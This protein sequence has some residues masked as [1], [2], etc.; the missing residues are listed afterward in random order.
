MT[1]N[2]YQELAMR[3]SSFES[4]LTAAVLG[5]C[6]ESGE[7]ADKIKKARCQGHALDTEE[8]VK[9]LGDVLWYIA[10]AG[11]ELGIS[12][13]IIAAANIAKLKLRYPRGFSKDE[14]KN[15]LAEQVARI[16]GE[17]GPDQP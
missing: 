11:K 14:S 15:R 4:D 2:E 17:Q 5:L 16:G 13:D 7:V 12:L 6:G 10:L 9:E 8:L 3:T 1:M